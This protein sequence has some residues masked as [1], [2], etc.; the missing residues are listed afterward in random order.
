MSRPALEA[1]NESPA[2]GGWRDRA[3]WLAVLSIRLALDA[4]LIDAAWET[5]RSPS[6]LRAAV[7][8]GAAAFF[9]LTLWVL[10]QG[11]R[12]GGR[13]WLTDPGAPLV[14]LLAF[15]VA[16]SGSR[17]G[18]ASGVVLLG[19]PAAAVLVWTLAVLVALAAVRLAGPAGFRA[20][21]ARLLCAGL[22]V[23]A[24]M[25]CALAARDGA[26]LAALVSGGGEWHV[27]PSWLRGARLGAFVLLPLALAREFW[28]YLVR[29]TFAGLLRWMI[30]FALGIWIAVNAAGL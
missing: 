23:Y 25:A 9:A 18:A 19:Q 8:L 4:L 3:R 21:W 20:W 11:G 7:A 29:L 12:I 14:L 26:T 10:S 13:G 6:P 16:A 28:V 30:I 1:A 22:G 15:L 2:T 17:E 24:V 27:L 5:W